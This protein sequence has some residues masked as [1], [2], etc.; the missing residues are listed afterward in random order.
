MIDILV[1][2]ALKASFEQKI[3]IITDLMALAAKSFSKS[4]DDVEVDMETQEAIW[5]NAK[6]YF[7]LCALGR[8]GADERARCTQ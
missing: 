3:H 5:F 8:Q 6:L 7:R 1:Q 2:A 4:V